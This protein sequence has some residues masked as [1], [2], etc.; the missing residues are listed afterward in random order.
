MLIDYIVLRAALGLALIAA[1]S[2]LAGTFAVLR[3][4]S[5][6]VAGVAHAALGGAALGVFLSS[7]GILP[8]DASLYGAV[9]AGLLLALAAAYVGERGAVGEMETA[10]GVA[11]ALAMC[12]AVFFMYYIPPEQAPKIWGFLVGDVMLLTDSDV[13]LLL[14]ITLAWLVMVVLFHREFTYIVFDIEGAEAHGLSVRRYHY[15]LLLM[16]AL[17]VTVST[18]AIGAIIVYAVMIAPVAAAA[19]ISNSM[20]KVFGYGF[21]FALT[22]CFSG[23]L[24]SLVLDVSPSAV[25]GMVS[26]SIYLATLFIKKGVG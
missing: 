23:L 25:A 9:G 2:A 18:K 8:F 3:G 12:V 26:A 24:L 14:C 13:L 19:N 22:A 17:S 1:L 11:F 16:I 6:I 4:L 20:K 5:F 10:I 7:S 15:A 21:A